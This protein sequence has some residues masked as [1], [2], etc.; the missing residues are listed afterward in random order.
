MLAAA[1]LAGAAVAALVV[2]VMGVLVQPRFT[3]LELAALRLVPEGR[4]A[5]PAVEQVER[6]AAFDRRYTVRFDASAAGV[7]EVIDAAAQQRWK[8][9][10]RSGG[11]LATLE[12]EGVRAV[13]AVTGG[14][15]RID[16]RIAPS[17]RAWQRWSVIAALVGG[18]A[19]GVWWTRRQLRGQA[20]LR[21]VK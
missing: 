8:V 13:V 4:T 18:A 17:V 2:A 3:V 1:A 6:F 15:A 10:T 20:T 14:T 5:Q 12:R 16:T 11:R 19:G 9:V 21:T 7:Q